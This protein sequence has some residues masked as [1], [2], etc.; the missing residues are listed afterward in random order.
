MDSLSIS[1][2]KKLEYKI[3]TII[4]LYESYSSIICEIFN[5]RKS[6]KNPNISYQIPS[7]HYRVIQLCE[8][9][10]FSPYFYL[11]NHHLDQFEL[12]WVVVFLTNNP[13]IRL[14]DLSNNNISSDG[15]KWISYFLSKNSTLKVLSLSGNNIED[16]GAKWLSHSLRLN[17]C[18]EGL[19]LGNNKIGKGGANFL[20]DALKTNTTLKG[21][22]LR[23]NR[24][25]SLFDTSQQTQLCLE[26]C[27]QNNPSL[28]FLD[29]SET[30][31]SLQEK[32]KIEEAVKKNE[33]RREDLIIFWTEDQFDQ[34]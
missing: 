24:F 15:S 32:R 1:I 33:K 26:T 21:L 2:S 6:L 34:Y 7:S 9:T 28:T 27:L 29:V 30:G 13:C 14:L 18:L 4:D 20:F 5:L 3:T 11:E 19:N 31:I 25:G 23:Q 17:S 16:E 10:K 8:E 22:S 12:K